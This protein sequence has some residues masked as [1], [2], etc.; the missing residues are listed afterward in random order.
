MPK[1]TPGDSQ[2]AAV[3]RRSRCAQRMHPRLGSI[4]GL[5]ESS[6]TGGRSA[7]FAGRGEP[8]HGADGESRTPMGFPAGS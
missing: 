3:L 7:G 4:R 6:H 1:N 5:G 8:E 2:E